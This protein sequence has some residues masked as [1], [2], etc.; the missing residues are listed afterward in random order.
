MRC[1]FVFAWQCACLRNTCKPHAS[2][3]SRGEGN[4]VRE[5]W[6]DQVRHGKH[7]KRGSCSIANWAAASAI[8]LGPPGCVLT[9]CQSALARSLHPSPVRNPTAV[10]AVP[11]RRFQARLP[12]RR[13]RL[14]TT[15]CRSHPILLQSR[16]PARSSAC[17]VIA[18]SVS[19]SVVMGKYSYSWVARIAWC[20]LLY[21]RCCQLL[22]LCRKMSRDHLLSSMPA[23]A[24]RAC[25]DNP[26]CV[27]ADHDIGRVLIR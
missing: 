5:T 20:H 13:M 15:A 14:R 4:S 24:G 27:L 11:A 23:C 6:K 8:C 10:L 16:S 7:W 17:S 9:S 3:D 18:A 1:A 25:C 26:S 2:K 21:P 12:I 19:R 22:D